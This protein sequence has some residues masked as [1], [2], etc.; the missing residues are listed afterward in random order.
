MTIV[1]AGVIMAGIGLIGMFKSDEDKR[2]EMLIEKELERM[3]E[4]IFC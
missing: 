1:V 4:G 2:V 3:D